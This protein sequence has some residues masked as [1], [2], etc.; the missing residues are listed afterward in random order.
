MNKL[1]KIKEHFNKF[2]NAYIIGFLMYTS[3]VGT[4]HMAHMLLPKWIDILIGLPLSIYIIS[5]SLII[6]HN[7]K[8][9]NYEDNR[10]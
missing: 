5:K 2:S 7:K 8:Y 4:N 9:E 10:S 6:F 1:N 3:F